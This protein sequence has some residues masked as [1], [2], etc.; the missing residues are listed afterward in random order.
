MDIMVY[1]ALQIGLALV[2]NSEGWIECVNA[3]AAGGYK[4][5]WRIN[6]YSYGFNGNDCSSLGRI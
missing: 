1:H 4:P 5:D 3:V 2:E 6:F